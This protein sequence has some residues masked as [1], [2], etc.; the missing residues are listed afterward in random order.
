MWEQAAIGL[1]H[2]LPDATRLQ[3]YYI[4]ILPTDF[5]INNPLH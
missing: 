4:D 3:K 2:L 1:G 5:R